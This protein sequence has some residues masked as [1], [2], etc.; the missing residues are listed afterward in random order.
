MLDR[1]HSIA[2]H[3]FK[4][5]SRCVPIRL[6]SPFLIALDELTSCGAITVPVVSCQLAPKSH[7][8]DTLVQ[9]LPSHLQ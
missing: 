4:V 2:G 5:L 9:H 3:L 6:S 7:R 1:S 8:G